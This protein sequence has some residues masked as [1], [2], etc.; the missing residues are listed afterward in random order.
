MRLPRVVGVVGDVLDALLHP[1]LVLVYVALQSLQRGNLL[2]QLG[3]TLRRVL[4][5]VVNGR[6]PVHTGPSVMNSVR[7][8]DQSDL[9]GKY[10]F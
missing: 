8:N 3:D 9:D 10:T 1:G 7:R 6:A 4:T 2:L 5:A